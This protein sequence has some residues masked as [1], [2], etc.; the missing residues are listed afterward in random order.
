MGGELCLI[1]VNNLRTC[2]LFCDL[3][4]LEVYLEVAVSEGLIEFAGCKSVE[5]SMRRM[6]GKRSLRL[7]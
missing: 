2:E 5:R 4:A 3:E 1:S 7:S 6:A